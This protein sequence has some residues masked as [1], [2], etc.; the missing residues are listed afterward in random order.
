MDDD[1]AGAER[2]HAGNLRKAAPESAQLSLNDAV[3][4]G[5]KNNPGIEVERLEPLRAAEQ[6]LAKRSIFDPMVNWI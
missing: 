1:C 2:L 6:T 4:L 5:L 3:L